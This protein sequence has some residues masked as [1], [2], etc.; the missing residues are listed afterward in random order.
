MTTSPPTAARPRCRLWIKL[1]ASALLLL[2]TPLACWWYLAWSEEREFQALLAETDR[3]DPVR[4][5]EEILAA[6]P[7]LPDERNS[8]K[9]AEIA[10][11]AIVGG[12]NSGV[13]LDMQLIRLPPNVPL[14]LR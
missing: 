14:P 7:A 12:A 1:A 11:S 3:L 5:L 13:D 2:G 10:W 9:Q 8:A 4:R 6:R